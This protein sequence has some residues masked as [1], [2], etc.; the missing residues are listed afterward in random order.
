ME[1]LNF[2]I[3]IMNFQFHYASQLLSIEG[4]FSY[5]SKFVRKTV[6]NTNYESNCFSLKK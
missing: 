3:T 5:F 1:N 6:R 2:S 4:K